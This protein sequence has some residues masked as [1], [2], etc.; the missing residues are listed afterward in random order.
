MNTNSTNRAGSAETSQQH[1]DT[2][3]ARWPVAK[4]RILRELTSVAM[5]FERVADSF[6]SLFQGLLLFSTRAGRRETGPD[7]TEQL[8]FEANDR[9]YEQ[10]RDVC[11]LFESADFVWRTLSFIG[12]DAMKYLSVRLLM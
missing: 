10:A 4:Q 11:R 1:R 6:L 9:Q 3:R 12:F 5:T 7:Y 2:A 8:I